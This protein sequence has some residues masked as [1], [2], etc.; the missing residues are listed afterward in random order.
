MDDRF[1]FIFIS[2]DLISGEDGVL[3]L[4]NSYLAEGQDGNH[5]NQ[6]VNDG[7]NSS[8]SQEIAD[9]LYYMSDHLPVSMSLVLGGT[10][11]IE[12]NHIENVGIKYDHYSKTLSL[13]NVK[14][15]GTL[16]IYNIEGAILKTAS[17]NGQ[18]SFTLE[19]NDLQFGIY[20]AHL[21]LDNVQINYKFVT[22]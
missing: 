21:V 15:N 6:S 7:L 8:V 2:E 9:A 19:L 14:E 18:S 4:E 1:D 12:E 17:I 20:I 13:E 3:Y 16:T 10:V 5:F 22:H 11:E